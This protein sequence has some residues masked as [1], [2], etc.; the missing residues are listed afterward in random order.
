MRLVITFT[1]AG[2]PG[3]PNNICGV[4]SE[5]PNCALP[6]SPPPG[7]P[8]IYVF[9]PNYQQPK[10]QQGSLGVD[11]Q[12]TKDMAVSLGYLYAKGDN[13][14]RTV[15]IN[16]GTPTP[17]TILDN[18]GNVVTYQKYPATRP[19]SDVQ[20]DL[21]VPEHGP[22]ALPRNDIAAEQAD[23]TPLLSADGVHLAARDR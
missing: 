23:V 19:I 13:L 12:L 7:K 15:D 11:Y 17:A 6:S 9:Q 2:M 20:P 8:T 16:L 10:I 18:V 14:Q 4:P 22:V 5:S 3:Y 1:G 21:P